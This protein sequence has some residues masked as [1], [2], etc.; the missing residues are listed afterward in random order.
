MN[1][2]TPVRRR[3]AAVERKLDAIREE[4]YG[5]L[6]DEI[7]RVCDRHDWDFYS[8]I[9]TFAVSRRAG[10]QGKEIEHRAARR[11]VDLAIWADEHG[12]GTEFEYVGGQFYGI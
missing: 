10:V 11:L 3:K 9:H 4:I 1:K 12:A 2:A 5:L 8:L 6:R 7:A